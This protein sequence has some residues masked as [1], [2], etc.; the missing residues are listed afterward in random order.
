MGYDRT[1]TD[2]IAERAG[3]SVG[4][5][6]QYYPTKDALLRKLVEHHIAAIVRALTP[7]ILGSDDST[8]VTTFLTA[9]TERYF[10]V[11]RKAPRLFQVLYE[12]APIPDSLLERVLEAES[13]ARVG[14]ANYLRVAP[15]VT[16]DRGA[17]RDMVMVTIEALTVRLIIYRHRGP[18]SKPSRRRRW[19]CCVATSPN[20]ERLRRTT[21]REPIPVTVVT[22]FLGAGKSTLLERWIA[23]QAEAAVILN[24]W[25]EVGHR[26]RALRPS[27]PSDRDHRRLP[28]L[29][30][31]AGARPRPGRARQRRSRPAAHS[32]R[33]VGGGVPGR[34]RA[35]GDERT[36]P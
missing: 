21:M 35:R 25:G 5:L 28:L 23:E 10:A 24:E 31:P 27:A 2:A 1:T 36:G 15:D 3:V 17:R 18:T 32:G 9:L 20:P 33:D 8:D 16:R 30:Q 6:Y 26:R 12:Q 13:A 34:R 29:H 4:T 22:G 14:V 19:R 11:R 7:V